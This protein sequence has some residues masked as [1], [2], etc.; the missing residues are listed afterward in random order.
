MKRIIFIMSVI[1][2]LSFSSL[3]ANINFS[4]QYADP[5]GS[6][7]PIKLTVTNDGSKGGHGYLYFSND[8]SYRI[9]RG[10]YQILSSRDHYIFRATQGGGT[11]YIFFK[12]LLQ[13]SNEKDIESTE[14]TFRLLKDDEKED[15]NGVVCYSGACKGYTIT[16]RY[17]VTIKKMTHRD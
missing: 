3:F 1:S 5:A 17:Q 12:L 6:R 2:F 16:N 14:A 8:N 7:I 4:L 13:D 11:T 10:V 15:P 9:S